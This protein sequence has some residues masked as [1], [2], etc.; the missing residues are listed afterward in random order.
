M[1]NQDNTCT[2]VSGWAGHDC[3]VSFLFSSLFL[4]F[5]FSFLLFLNSSFTLRSLP[6]PPSL[7]FRVVSSLSG[8]FDCCVDTKRPSRI[9]RYYPSPLLFFPSFLLLVFSL[10]YF[11]S[12]P[13]LSSLLLL[14]SLSLNLGL[15]IGGSGLLG[16]Y[17]NGTNFETYLGRRIDAT[18]NFNVGGG[19][20]PLLS[21]SPSFFYILFYLFI[22]FPFLTVLFL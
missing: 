21:L 19:N 5:F 12:S 15:S 2:C 14:F 18:I 8:L 7:S 16:S 13:L 4:L 1:C 3:S 9:P 17:Y 11:I 6:R 20:P 10:S 22:L